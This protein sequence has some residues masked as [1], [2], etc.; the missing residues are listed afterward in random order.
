MEEQYNTI[1][2]INDVHVS[3]VLTS[4][5]WSKVKKIQVRVRSFLSSGVDEGRE[6]C[7]E[8]D[9]VNVLEVAVHTTD[10][11]RPVLSRTEFVL[12]KDFDVGVGIE[13][14]ATRVLLDK[15]YTKFTRKPN[16]INVRETMVDFLDKRSS[17]SNK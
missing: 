11:S 2:I 5:V 9:G 12:T 13:E 14:E 6:P 1:L 15:V 7:A 17:P 8:S 10:G 3:D 16:V 4:V